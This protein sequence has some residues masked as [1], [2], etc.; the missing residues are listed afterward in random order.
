MD[1]IDGWC[2]MDK[3]IKRREGQ[4]DYMLYVLRDRWNVYRQGWRDTKPVG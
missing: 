4:I 3:L 2:W 1:G